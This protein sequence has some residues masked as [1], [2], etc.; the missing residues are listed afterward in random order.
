MRLSGS[1]KFRCPDPAG[2]RPR[3]ATA[4]PAS[5]FLM[6][7]PARSRPE[8]RADWRP[9]PPM[10]PWRHRSLRAGAVCWPSSPA[11]CLHADPH[12]APHPR[13]RRSR[14]LDPAIPRPRRPV[15]AQPSSSG[16]SSLPCGA[17][18]WPSALSRRPRHGRTAPALP[19]GTDAALERTGPTTPR[20]GA[21]GISSDIRNPSRSATENP[22][23][24]A[25]MMPRSEPMRVSP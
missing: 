4:G 12:H 16:H 17:R 22:S 6:R 19:P 15:P 14:G 10:P 9:R 11:S 25:T 24:P 21:C 3:L 7:R 23:T 1:V 5:A 2:R 8:D 13:P 20:D 18:H